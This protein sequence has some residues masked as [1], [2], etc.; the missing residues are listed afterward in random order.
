MKSVQQTFKKDPDVCAACGILC[1][2][3]SE[4][5]ESLPRD[6][7]LARGAAPC[8]TVH[9]VG[10]EIFRLHSR[11]VLQVE[12]E[13]VAMFCPSCD[14]ALQKGK[15]TDLS[16]AGGLDY[17]QIPECL[18]ALS[19]WERMSIARVRPFIN[20]VKLTP[21]GELRLDGH[22]ISFEHDAAERLSNVLPHP[23]LDAD[24]AVMFV[25][26]ADDW[27][28]K[29]S[30]VLGRVYPHLYELFH[31]DGKKIT[32]SI[33]F[34]A[35]NN[36]FWSDVVFN[37]ENVRRV[38]ACRN[39]A[40]DNARV[41]SE[42]GIAI[43]AVA[44][45]DIARARP[46]EEHSEDVAEHADGTKPCSV[47]HVLV[48]SPYEPSD[49]NVLTAVHKLMNGENP[50]VSIRADVP[51][52]EF[53]VN[54]E[55][56]YKMFPNLFP[57]GEG[58]GSSSTVSDARLK[59]LLMFHDG[60]FARELDFVFLMCNQMSRHENIR[61]VALNVCGKTEEREAFMDEINSKQFRDE[62]AIAVEDYQK[63][64]LDKKNSI[65]TSLSSETRKLL[66]KM[67][68]HLRLGTHA[69]KHGPMSRDRCLSELRGL[70]TLYGLPSLF[71]TLAPS[72]IDNE[73]V[74]R[75]TCKADD[76]GSFDMRIGNLA[77]K[78]VRSA[79]ITSNPVYCAKVFQKIFDVVATQLYGLQMSRSSD[80]PDRKKVVE[81]LSNGIFGETLAHYA[82]VEAQGR[83][84]L[85]LHQLV[86][87]SLSPS[88][89]EAALRS[90]ETIDALRAAIDGFISYDVGEGNLQTHPETNRFNVVVPL[91]KAD[92]K[93]SWLAVT[94]QEIPL[95][96][97]RR[98]FSDRAVIGALLSNIHKHYKTCTHGARGKRMKCR[99]GMAQ[100]V[101]EES[102]CPIWL[103]DGVTM[104]LSDAS[105]VY[106]KPRSAV[107]FQSSE[108][109]VW[110]SHRE[111]DQVYVSPFNRLMMALFMSNQNIS[112]LGAP[113]QC[114]SAIYYVCSY[115]CKDAK[116]LGTAL[117][118]LDEA[119]KHTDAYPSTHPEVNVS[120][121]DIAKAQKG[122]TKEQLAEDNEARQA[123]KEKRGFKHVMQRWVNNI[124]ARVETSSQQAAAMLLGDDP[125][126]SSESFWW[127]FGDS[128]LKFL[129]S[130]RPE[131]FL[132]LASDG[133][134]DLPT[135]D[136]EEEVRD[137]EANDG[138]EFYGDVW[139][140]E[141]LREEHADNGAAESLVFREGHI[142][143]VGQH[144]HYMYCP[145]RN[146]I[147]LYEFTA[148]FEVITGAR[149]QEDVG[150]RTTRGSRP[151]NGTV[152]F[153][154]NH[155]IAAML[156]QHLRLRSKHAVPVL[157]GN[158][159]PH[160]GPPPPIAPDNST[161][162]K[163]WRKRANKWAAFCVVTFLPWTEATEAILKG[164][165]SAFEAWSVEVL[166]ASSERLGDPVERA[167]NRA[168]LQAMMNATQGLRAREGEKRLCTD[169]K[170]RGT[171]NF[172]KEEY[173]A[174]MA[175]DGAP[176]KK[177]TGAIDAV[178]VLRELANLDM[179][180]TVTE[181]DPL[182]VRASTTLSM[183]Y[184]APAAANAMNAT[185]VR[186]VKSTQRALQQEIDELFAATA[187]QP[188][189]C[190]KFI[191]AHKSAL[192]PP[193][194]DTED[195]HGV[196]RDADGLNAGQAAVCAKF[197]E[198][199]AKKVQLLQV[200]LGG[201]GTGK[202]HMMNH[203][204]SV[205]G[206]KCIRG[207]FTG[208]AASLIFGRTLHSMFALSR[209]ERCVE[210]RKKKPKCD[211]AGVHILLID[212]VSQ[213]TGKML[214]EID[215]KCRELKKRKDLPFG[216]MH[217]ILCG[218]F[219]QLP[220]VCADP[221]YRTPGGIFQKFQVNV[222]TEQMRSTDEAH[223]RNV[224]VMRRMD[225]ENPMD[226]FDFGKYANLGARDLAD[227][228]WKFATHVVTRNKLRRCINY[229]QAL[230]WSAQRSVPFVTWN[231]KCP[232]IESQSAEAAL[233]RVWGRLPVDQDSLAMYAQDAPCVLTANINPEIGL[234]NGTSAV[235]HALGF[236]DEE[237]HEELEQRIAAAQPGERIHLLQAPDYIMVKIGKGDD[238]VV[239]P[240]QQ[241]YDKV[242]LGKKEIPC[243]RH[244]VEL[245]FAITY[246]KVQGQTLPNAI[247]H[248]SGMRCNTV[249]S[250]F[251]V[252]ISRVKRGSHLRFFP[253][254][255]AEKNAI[256]QA[257][258]DDALRRYMENLKK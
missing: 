31:V 238:A 132:S 221:L 234:C 21:K 199:I 115:C 194:T 214:D 135:S 15:A 130:Q 45:S 182:S 109:V 139:D 56:I 209:G 140:G 5:I 198:S 71:V 92:L 258:P 186:L 18:R 218:D 53:L 30:D 77:N 165:Y 220:P 37:E 212:E 170:Y 24:I 173:L 230:R 72:D 10:N 235:M 7:F 113:S 184:G 222:L 204:I 136:T 127:C 123:T 253:P 251:L 57:F 114:R 100:G 46:H 225:G 190:A 68:K 87:T 246:W 48:S 65:D 145:Y 38:S 255:A 20:T 91:V 207:A 35:A 52:N 223:N 248:L 179:H 242:S 150:T 252:G 119:M 3:K 206:L 191:R 257:V 111:K 189:S 183:M 36:R 80:A 62:L 9:Q 63:V 29:K 116:V 75:F 249:F 131:L 250:M 79:L 90:P 14:A 143:T 231:V 147:S 64:E 168:R 82:V 96:S 47:E 78:D 110:E 203:F 196:V 94:Q 161:P 44:T 12:G 28:K 8:D 174:M 26:T 142:S 101:W 153:D 202:T 118:C 240:I 124:T 49:T 61:N 34:L 138:D 98:E 74:L 193:D 247:L 200:V 162:W 192:A 17:R 11:G 108:V 39:A 159:P 134:I 23:N 148:I 54:D 213:L 197:K 19:L 137:S 129:R 243:L 141:D 187:D 60:R 217:V 171:D 43:D 121:E 50:T 81:T 97:N 41:V 175:V 33:E 232:R 58:L 70:C 73:L 239:I 32:E 237:K 125:A 55:L 67:T 167:V 160:P 76:K 93:E 99:M 40:L 158:V 103:R 216:G 69:L 4:P 227:D 85:H 151:L 244:M 89:F 1:T 201:P 210:M 228:N 25:G 2:A 146:F 83:G 106:F 102:T 245:G 13:V 22:V 208:I 185:S 107:L 163:R 126:Q 86:W 152:P 195:A 42:E 27:R 104:A 229:E 219:I 172:S 120:A 157:S 233:Q 241:G 177:T 95:F 156:N 169:F 133:S 188:E 128:A 51:M 181:L 211:L 6:V 164:G 155:R 149:E 224:D 254:N 256:A 176:Q 59:H 105:E 205:C 112:L 154:E 117:V 144:M 236:Y 88:I 226:S 66:R 215:V 122:M 180:S 166:R 178:A 16:L 84:A